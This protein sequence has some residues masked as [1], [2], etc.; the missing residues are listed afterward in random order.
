MLYTCAGWRTPFVLVNVSRALAAPITLEP[1]HNDVLATRDCGALQIHCSSCQEVLDTVLMAY[2]I[3]EHPDVRLPVIVNIDGFHLSFTREPVEI[4]DLAKARDFVGEFDAGSLTFRASHPVSQAVAV[5]GGGPYSY[6][7]YEMQL[8]AERAIEVYREVGESFAQRFG[9]SHAAV[10]AY[11]M[12]DA[13][14]AF[15]MIG[16]F[17]T[18]ARAAVDLLRASGWRIGLVRPRMIRPFPRA[19]LRDLLRSVRGVAVIDQ[20]LSL[21]SGGILFTELSAALYALAP[22]RPVIASFIG[23][24]GGRDIGANEFAAMAAAIRDAA[25]TG[26]VPAPRLLFTKDE[27][28]E[29][30]KMQAIAT[31]ERHELGARP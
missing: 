12:E 17:A 26:N 31:V 14:Y 6:F 19:L 7:R 24:L 27:L 8:A 1:D 15:V 25:V 23:G 2:R 20:N 4:P 30:R 18:K 5:L 13:E 3:A 21:G 16:S 11:R 28:R 22:A 29:I 10:D 9:R